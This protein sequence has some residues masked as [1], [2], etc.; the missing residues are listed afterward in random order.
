MDNR[1]DRTRQKRLEEK[2]A[3]IAKAYRKWQAGQ[4]AQCELIAFIAGIIGRTKDYSEKCELS[5]MLD[6]NWKEFVK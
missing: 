2:K 6:V 4:I 1:K 5:A 3:V